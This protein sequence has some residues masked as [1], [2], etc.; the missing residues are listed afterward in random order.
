MVI[1]QLLFIKVSVSDFLT[2]FSA[3]AHE[4]FFWESRPSPILMG[5]G[6]LALT[7]STIL[8]IAWPQGTLDGIA[9]EGMGHHPSQVL[10]LWVWFY[11]L[12]IWLVQDAAKVVCYR[13]LYKYNVYGIKDNK[14]G[15]S[16]EMLELDR[17][18]E[19]TKSRTKS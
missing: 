8:S 5:A 16:T 3:R 1:L 4:G 18:K 11:C 10:F 15:R 19:Q 13:L 9:V 2:L 17:E 6:C 12:L 7:L 14:E